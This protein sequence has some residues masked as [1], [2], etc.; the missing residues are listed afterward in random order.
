MVK[1]VAAPNALITVVF[2]LSRLKATVLKYAPADI[3]P[4]P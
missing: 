3:P 4:T 2:V 1:F